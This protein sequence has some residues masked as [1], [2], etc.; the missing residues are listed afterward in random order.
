MLSIDPLVVSADA[1]DEAKTY[2]RI[3]QDDEDASIAA[4]LSASIRHCELFIGQVILRRGA[5][6][7]IAVS[8]DWKRLSLTPVQSI[9]SITGLPAEGVPFILPVAA[10]GLDLDGNGDGWVR[11]MQ[12]GNAQRV[13]VAVQAGLANSWG[14]VPDAIR[15]AVLR[16]ASHLHSHRD[17]HDDKGPPVA[18]AALLQP[19][20]RMV[21]S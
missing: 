18:V 6:D 10:Y 14:A 9:T 3:E 5:V 7:R 2:L 19:Y 16:L 17:N 13:D 8:T 4:F 15:H 1:V 21:L 12:P 20:R 11:V